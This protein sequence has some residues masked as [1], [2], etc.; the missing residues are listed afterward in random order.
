MSQGYGGT[1]YADAVASLQVSLS[2]LENSVNTLG[3]AVTDYPRLGSVLKTVRHYELIPQPTLAAAEASLR[4]EIGPFIS[5]LLDRAEHTVERSERR[6]DTLKA[7]AELN[8]GRLSRSD[9][10][11]SSSSS[12]VARFGSKTY[13]EEIRTT[14]SLSSK[15]KKSSLLGRKKLGPEAKLKVKVLQQRKAQLQ[16]SIERLEL[17]VAQKERELRDRKSVV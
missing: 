4:D 7:R 1:S 8:Q 5:L 12:A 16:Y 17:E 3:E 9:E 6:I 10:Y 13:K 11:G 2:S 14:M 15:G